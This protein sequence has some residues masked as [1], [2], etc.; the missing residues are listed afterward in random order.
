MD[1]HGFFCISLSGGRIVLFRFSDKNWKPLPT[2]PASTIGC[3]LFRCIVAK[4]RRMM[5]MTSIELWVN[6]RYD[7]IFVVSIPSARVV[8]IIKLLA[9][10]TNR[11]AQHMSLLWCWL[12]TSRL[13]FTCSLLSP[14]K[15][16]VSQIPLDYQTFSSFIYSIAWLILSLSILCYGV[17]LTVHNQPF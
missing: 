11:E 12:Y 8:R 5:T 17:K 15:R 7:R 4:R 16:E 9:W 13:N 3:I 1:K 10:R 6:S 14:P 2:L